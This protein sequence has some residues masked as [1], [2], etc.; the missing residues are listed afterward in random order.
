[1]IDLTDEAWAEVERA[2]LSTPERRRGLVWSIL[3]C[4]FGWAGDV[5]DGAD[6]ERMQAFIVHG[7]AD[8]CDMRKVDQVACGIALYLDRFG[9]TWQPRI[10]GKPNTLQVIN[11]RVVR[12]ED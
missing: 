10:D 6:E 5:P 12:R 3:K 8:P 7:V 4:E 9:A 1:V 2:A 11:G